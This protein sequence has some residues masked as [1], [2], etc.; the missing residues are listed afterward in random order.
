MEA[1][2]LSKNTRTM[3]NKY[4]TVMDM[5]WLDFRKWQK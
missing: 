5:H 3:I 2:R 1:L 4:M